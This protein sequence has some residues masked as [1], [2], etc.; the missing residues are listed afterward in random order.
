MAI[1]AAD[2]SPAAVMTWAR[3][4]GE[5]AR[6]PDAGDAGMTRCGRSTPNRPVELAAEVDEKVVVRD[7][8]RWHEQR[9]AGDDAPVSHLDSVQPI[10]LDHDPL[11][12]ALHDP[13]RP[14]PEL[15]SCTGVRLSSWVKKTTSSDHCRTIW[16]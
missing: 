16:V 11:H 7:E 6:G 15:C 13:D 8:A 4:F 9:I 2:P 12:A 14:G 1:A 3:G 10:V 5:I